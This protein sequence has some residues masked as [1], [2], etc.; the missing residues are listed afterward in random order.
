[1]DKKQGQ[2]FRDNAFSVTP[3]LPQIALG[4]SDAEVLH[5][6]RIRAPADVGHEMVNMPSVA[7]PFT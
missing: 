7:T 6:F 3:T 2:S 4:A 5:L 1:M